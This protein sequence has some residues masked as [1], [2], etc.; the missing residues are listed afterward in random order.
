MSCN[1]W[2]PTTTFLQKRWGK[3]NNLQQ[4]QWTDW[5]FTD[6]KLNNTVIQINMTVFTT[7]IRIVIVLSAWKSDES[8]PCS[9]CIMYQAES[10]FHDGREAKWKDNRTEKN[11][12]KYFEM[13]KVADNPWISY[14]GKHPSTRT[15]LLELQSQSFEAAINRNTTNHLHENSVN[16]WGGKIRKFH[17]E[18][19]CPRSKYRRTHDEGKY[20]KRKAAL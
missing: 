7:P 15:L 9:T 10:L 4:D 13:T 20:V 8:P 5:G 2:S 17:P 12:L 18:I 1:I 6:A 3:V 14:H 11:N 19:S 16:E